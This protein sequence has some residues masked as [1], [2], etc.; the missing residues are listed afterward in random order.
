MGSPRTKL[1]VSQAPE[2]DNFLKIDG[3]DGESPDDKHKNEIEVLAIKFA[4]HQPPTTDAGGGAGAGIASFK[5]C[6][7]VKRIDKS[8][9]KLLKACATGE[10]LKKAVLTYR[11]AGKDQQDYMV[12][13]FSDVLITNYETGYDQTDTLP[14][15]QFGIDFSKIEMEYKAQGSD[16]TL[17]GSTK[18][19]WNMK[20]R[21]K[22]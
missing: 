13:T 21:K 16:G 1:H 6:A 12:V 11:K 19:G 14:T 4:V 3:I 15:D 17:K 2:T 20:E 8:S 5:D 18:A 22:I 7:F 10:H 9:P